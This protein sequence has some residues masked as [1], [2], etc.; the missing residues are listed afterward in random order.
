M[1]RTIAIL[2]SLI[3]VVSCVAVLVACDPKDK[4]GET[5]DQ[6]YWGGGK[7]VVASDKT[8]IVYLG[9]S[10]AEGILGAS[11]LPLRHEYAYANV[12]GRRNDFTYYNHSVSGHLTDDML[13]LISNEEGYDG[14]RGLISHIK[15]ADVLHISILGNDVLQDREDVKLEGNPYGK[16]VSM[17]QVVC[18]AM[19]RGNYDGLNIAL[20]GDAAGEGR[21]GSYGYVIQIIDRLIELNPDAVIIFQKIYNPIANVDTPLV[22]ADTR[23]TLR[24]AGVDVTTLDSLHELGNNLIG[25]MN[26]LLQKAVD[27]FNAAKTAEDKWTLTTVDGLAAFNKIYDE[28]GAAAAWKLIYPDGIHPSDEGHAVLADLTQAKLEELGIANKNTALTNYKNMRCDFIDSKFELANAAEVKAKISAATSCA[29]VTDIFFRATEGV[30][31]DYSID[32]S[33]PVQ[34]DTVVETQFR[35]DTVNTSVWGFPGSMIGGLLDLEKSGIFLRSDGTMSLRLI[36]NETASSTINE[37]LGELLTGGTV[38]L[39]SFEETYLEPIAP[40]ASLDDI[41]ALLD[42]AYDCLGLK[43][44]GYDPANPDPGIAA[45]IEGLENGRLPESLSIPAGFGVELNYNYTMKKVQSANGTVYD[46]VYLT[47]YDGDTQPFIVMTMGSK[48]YDMN[49]NVAPDDPSADL[50]KTDGPKT[51][52]TLTFM[53]DFIK[54]QFSAIENVDGLFV[55]PFA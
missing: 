25:R 52:R 14:A 34:S 21:G 50:Y 36:L 33:A 16:Y 45:L 15:T 8:E 30:T 2:L 55:D 54:L 20:Y 47:P 12:I 29:E 38:D 10:I 17:H 35:I 13:A 19:I 1:K 31:P 6:F 49:P 44:I 9:D 40:G 37:M 27:E 48:T 22:K 51:A 53:V 46:A 43:L 18:D 39:S 4:G 23:A 32:H 41:N 24:K 26:A 42:T 28:K 3:L 7:E 11:P 5:V